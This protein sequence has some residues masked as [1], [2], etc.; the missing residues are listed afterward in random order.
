MR[1]LVACMVVAVGLST[2]AAQAAT[3][4]VTG[5]NRGIGFEL[6]KQ[7]ADRGWTVIATARNP[8][9]ATELQALAAKNKN[10][11]V[12]K[13]DLVDRPGIKALAAK[14]AGTPIDVLINNAGVLGD[15]KGQT[16]GTFDYA[17]FEEVMAVNV[18]GALAVSEAFVPNIV[19]SEQKKII[20]VTSGVGMISGG[21]GR[22]GNIY[23]YS[24]SKVGLNMSMKALGGD[25]RN[26]GVTVG[27]ISPEAADTDMRRALVGAQRAAK[28][29]E[30]AEVAAGMIKVIDGLTQETAVSPF[31][32]DGRA[33]PW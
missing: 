22:G 2:S 14:L 31:N 18:Y 15:L 29:P 33:L 24:I 27:I 9:S 6:V 32:W 28:D 21:R 26:R 17:N 19:A 30:P 16:L 8:E 20:G 4:L 25:L 5:S 7:Y 12:E 23:F 10:V 1:R 11:R 13:L 3:V